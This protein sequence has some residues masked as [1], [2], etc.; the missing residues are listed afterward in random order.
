MQDPEKQKEVGELFGGEVDS[1]EFF[2][3]VTIGKLITDYRAA[4]EPREGDIV[5]GDALDEDTGVAVEFEGEDEE[6]DEEDANE[7]VVSPINMQ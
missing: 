1:D 5:A 2:R 4:D 7:I 6:E 3:L